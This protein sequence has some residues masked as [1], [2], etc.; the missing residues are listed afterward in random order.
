[1]DLPILSPISIVEALAWIVEGAGDSA[2]QPRVETTHDMSR[3]DFI[4]SPASEQFSNTDFVPRDVPAC[5]LMYSALS[6][7][8]SSGRGGSFPKILILTKIY[9][10]TPRPS[11]HNVATWRVTKGRSP[12]ESETPTGYTVEYRGKVPLSRALVSSP[13][14]TGIGFRLGCWI[15]SLTVVDQVGASMLDSSHPTRRFCV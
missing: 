11:M 8:I 9:L 4:H 13:A 2:Q 1:M 12:E 14:I 10:A 15:A 3:T 5:T 7:Q 6:G